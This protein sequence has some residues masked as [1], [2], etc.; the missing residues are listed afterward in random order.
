MSR[1]S[2]TP[3]C[4]DGTIAEA[5]GALSM[6][7]RLLEGLPEAGPPENVDR[8]VSAVLGELEGLRRRL[9]T[10]ETKRA[11][12]PAT[13][14]K[15][16]EAWASAQ[17]SRG[18]DPRY[19]RQ[20]VAR[21][22]ETAEARGWKSVDDVSAR[23]LEEWLAG[24]AKTGTT[25]NKLLGYW[26]TFLEWARRTE[27]VRVNVA[28]QLQKARQLGEGLSTRAFTV[29]EATA[30]IDWAKRDGEDPKSRRKARD[31]WIVYLVAWH[32]GLRRSE[33]RRITVGMLAL[34]DNP[35]RILLGARIAKARKA[36]TIPLHPDLIEP[37][38]TLAQGKP[39][40]SKLFPFLRDELVAQDI[41][42]AGVQKIVDGLTCGLHSFRKGLATELAKAG[43]AE[44]VAQA[45]LR[46][47]D[48]R[49]TR[50]VYTDSRLLPLAEA[51]SGVGRVI[52]TKG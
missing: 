37:L 3:E 29:A 23:G 52:R 17:A 2:H 8:V 32:T 34:G 20:G 5:R 14:G 7:L 40:H 4:G 49:L 12:M 43:V 50:N 28:K 6:A 38:R 41:K 26:T 48:P 9:E 35:P 11:A 16:I 13:I 25:Y 51:S 31:R 36:Q 24:R 45:L 21:L 47:S 33:L 46:H 1:Q 44:G 10:S 19:L 39:A 27:R 15:D 30:I 18:L 22:L 42:L